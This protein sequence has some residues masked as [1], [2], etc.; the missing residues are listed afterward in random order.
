MFCACARPCMQCAK[1]ESKPQML[2]VQVYLVKRQKAEV[3][4][5]GPQLTPASRRPAI[6]QPAASRRPGVLRFT[7]VIYATCVHV[8]VISVVG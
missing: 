2:C 7:S 8:V 3:R 5:R 6:G 1:G 4:E